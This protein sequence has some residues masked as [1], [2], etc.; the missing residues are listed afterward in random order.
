MDYRFKLE[1]Y[2]GKGTRYTC[3]Q[4]G[5]AHKFTRYVDTQTNQYIDDHVGICDRKDSCSYHYTPQQFFDENR[6]N[7]QPEQCDDA[8]K[9]AFSFNQG[10]NKAYQPI[11]YIDK[12]T[13]IKSLHVP[14]YEKNRFIK[15]LFN[16]YDNA[17]V[18]ELIQKYYI[19]NS[20]RWPG[21]TVF[22]QVDTG[23]NI[24]TGKIMQYDQTTGKRVKEPE[25]RVAWVHKVIK[26]P[27]FNM[28]QCFFGEHLL[29]GN[30]YPVCIVESEKTAILASVHVPGKIWLATGGKEGLS[31][32][33][34]RVLRNR[35]VELY[36]DL[37]AY[38]QWL[39]RA[40]E[41]SQIARFTV[42]SYLEQIATEEEKKDGL[43]IADYLIAHINKEKVNALMTTL[44]AE[45]T[46][47]SNQFAAGRKTADE[48]LVCTIAMERKL[49]DYGIPLDEF[50]N[51]TLMN[52]PKQK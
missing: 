22:W 52:H 39:T 2:G 51:A 11:S 49:K 26:Q 10:V 24:R 4:C 7:K 3:P 18:T 5:K 48:Y 8:S 34:C 1:P 12:N 43:D 44:V 9:R 32:S 21:A 37:K 33:K 29:K 17:T 42:S 36:P 35:K 15:Y 6:G 28:Q 14:D 19:G 23:G 38:D 45:L 46:E 20:D 41:L 47:C 31:E 40:A 25:S 16:L 13:F 50:V 30:D 27:G